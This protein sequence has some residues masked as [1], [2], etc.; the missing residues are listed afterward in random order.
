MP[1]ATVVWII[2][3]AVI[4]VIAVGAAC[5]CCCKP[6]PSKEGGEGERTLFKAVKRN[7]KKTT[8]KES[9]V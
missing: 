1:V 9:L 4:V 3:S 8:V 5:Y 7:S 2:S 6:P